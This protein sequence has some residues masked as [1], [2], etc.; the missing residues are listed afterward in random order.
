MLFK[1]FSFFGDLLKF[2]GAK[3]SICEQFEPFP[4]NFCWQINAF[5]DFSNGAVSSNWCFLG[6]A[7][8]HPET[9]SE[10]GSFSDV[11]KTV[12]SQ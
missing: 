11:G 8:V 7:G 5:E 9:F 6:V 4:S 1:I 10:D 2:F 3:K 12:N